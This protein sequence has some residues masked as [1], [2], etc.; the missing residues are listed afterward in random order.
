MTTEAASNSP[1]G[2]AGFRLLAE[3][4]PNLILLP[5]TV[6]TEGPGP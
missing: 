6:P 1:A 2:E 3:H 5:L 4:L